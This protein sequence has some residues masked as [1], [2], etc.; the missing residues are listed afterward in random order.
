ME[1]KNIAVLDFDLAYLALLSR[2]GL[3]P[4]CRWEKSIKKSHLDVLN[5]MGL[6]T[7]CIKRKLK[8]GDSS[9]EVVFS[10]S[11]AWVD[12]YQ[13]QFQN[14]PLIKSDKNIRLE[15]YLFGFPSC[16]IENFIQHGYSSNF[17]AR[18]DQHILF[19]WCCP[20]CNITPLLVPEYRKIYN[21][22]RH[23]F[24]EK[25]TI[26]NNFFAGENVKSR[27]KTAATLSLIVGT[28]CLV[29]I[30]G[31]AAPHNDDPHLTPFYEYDD[32]DQDYIK[33]F[34]ETILGLNPELFD[35]DGDGV[36]DGVQA[37]KSL[38][39]QLA[40]LPHEPRTDGPYITDY[41]MYGLETCS[42]CD[43]VVNMGYA[44]IVNP[45][46]NL[47]MDIPYI[48]FHHYLLHGSLSYEG[49]VHSKDDINPA[50]LD[51]IL[52]GKGSSHI[53]SVNGDTDEDG[54]TDLEE[55]FCGTDPTQ[56]DSD[57]D[58][59]LDGRQTAIK[60]AE[61]VESLPLVQKQDSLYAQDYSYDGVERCY[62][63]GQTFNM[64]YRK[65]I[66][67]VK[68]LTYDLSYITIHY[69]KCG[70]FTYNGEVHSDR[71]DI[72]AL[73]NVISLNSDDH[74]LFVLTDNDQDGLNNQEESELTLDPQCWDS[75]M[76]GIGDG[77]ELA[78]LLYD[79][80]QQLPIVN[81]AD[82][83][84]KIDY[85]QRGIEA[86]GVCAQ[87]VN[88]GYI[89]LVNPVTAES[90]KIDYIALHYLQHGSFSYFGAIHQ[91]RVDPVQLATFFNE[92]VTNVDDENDPTPVQLL[93]GQ[94]YPNPFNPETVIPF[95]VHGD[96]VLS[97]SV[98]IFNV[99]GKEICTLFEGQKE[100]GQYSLLW[101]GQ[102]DQGEI[103]PS[104]VYVVQIKSGHFKQSRFISL[105]K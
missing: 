82:Q 70:G 56:A 19:H 10:A 42:K 35:S 41:M 13:A 69:L 102:D 34:F 5:S 78:H 61:L 63:C 95:Q 52:N 54:L 99:L 2:E 79:R 16:C 100:K 45:M 89:E 22:C 74:E 97:L 23:L 27:L 17:L 85:A 43:S 51:V 60:I 105:L 30:S 55:P 77:A 9:E 103:M 29:P 64:G 20:D 15:G 96:Q 48:A 58:G 32:H 80:I 49:D 38:Y 3:K 83:I 1:L 88:M 40:Q 28:S 18:E 91:G 7:R 21:I 86:C 68:N 75:D 57:Q 39:K 26:K 62:I 25:G 4:L 12:F 73:L 72:K 24:G 50:L 71:I 11:G 98:K 94:N 66:N 81:P 104:G 59:V 44:V 46:E 76:D 65:I 33:D 92:L 6:K 8:N 37:A 14:T 101:N 93:L 84:Y 47:S 90:L 31:L 87:D 67:P 53:Y 36:A